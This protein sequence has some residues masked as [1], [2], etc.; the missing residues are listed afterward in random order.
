MTFIANHINLKNYLFIN[1]VYNFSTSSAIGTRFTIASLPCLEEH[2]P[3][4]VIP[5]LL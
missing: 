3:C 1:S 4:K 5:I 2:I